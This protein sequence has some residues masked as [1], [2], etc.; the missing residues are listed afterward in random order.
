MV[1]LIYSWVK[2]F[3]FLLVLKSQL[4]LLM[5]T[6]AAIFDARKIISWGKLILEEDQ[7]V[8]K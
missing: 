4:E 2:P 1:L 8:L 6:Y 3:K 7:F 5:E